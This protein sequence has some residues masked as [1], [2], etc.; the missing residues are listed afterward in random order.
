MYRERKPTS[1][2]LNTAALLMAT[3]CLT[4]V[5]ASASCVPSP[6]QSG[7]L[8]VCTGSD[9]SGVGTGLEENVKLTVSDGAS[10]VYSG[11]GFAVQ[12]GKNSQVT[13]SGSISDAGVLVGAFSDIHN[14]VTGTIEGLTEGLVAVESTI[15]NEGTVESPATAVRIVDAD[16]TNDGTISAI[17]GAGGVPIALD[18]IGSTIRNNGKIYAEGG[19]FSNVVGVFAGN[20]NDLTNDGLIHANA[21]G[22]DGIAIGVWGP[23][24]LQNIVTNNDTIRVDAQGA[25]TGLFLIDGKVVNNGELIVVGGGATGIR[26]NYG[27]DLKNTG[28]IT[29]SGDGGAEAVIAGGNSTVFNS[30]S[31]LASGGEN[32]VGI[33]GGNNTSGALSVWNSGTIDAD[34]AITVT[35][36]DTSGTAVDVD[37]TGKIQGAILLGDAGDKLVN[38]P[39]GKIVGDIVMGDGSDVVINAGL[40]AGDISLG[41]GDDFF[42]RDADAEPDAEGTVDAGEGWDSIGIYSNDTESGVLKLSGGFEAAAVYVEDWAT[43]TIAEGSGDADGMTVSLLGSGLVINDAGLAA[44]SGYATVALKSEG[45]EFRNANSISAGNHGIETWNRNVVINAANAEVTSLNFAIDAGDF[46]DILNAGTL[47]SETG[48][49]RVEFLNSEDMNGDGYA[50]VT[51]QGLI[52]APVGIFVA[53]GTIVGGATSNNLVTNGIDG[54]IKAHT[55]I[56]VSSNLNKI[57]NQG[58]IEGE[59]YGIRIAGKSGNWVVNEA[60]GTVTAGDDGVNVLGDASIVYNAGTIAG[61]KNG[62]EDGGSPDD[63]KAF[64]VKLEGTGG[65][66][67]NVAGQIYSGTGHGIY[68]KGNGVVVENMSDSIAGEGI[69]DS[70]GSQTGIEGLDAIRIEGVGN[71]ITNTGLVYSARNGVSLAGVQNSLGNAGLIEADTAVYLDGIDHTITNDGTL[72]GAF[73]AVNNANGPMTLKNSGLISGDLLLGSSGDTIELS[74]GSRIKGDIVGGS[75]YDSITATGDAVLDG[76]IT[77]VDALAVEDGTLILQLDDGSS[78]TKT[79]VSGGTLRLQGT[80]ATSA[81]VTADGGLAGIGTLQGNV[82]NQGIV[83]PGALNGVLKISG[84]YSQSST[85][86]MFVELGAAGSNKLAVTGTAALDGL[87]VAGLI[88]RDLDALEGKSYTVLTAGS[89]VGSFDTAGTVQQGFWTLDVQ[90]SGTAVTVTVTDVDL[91]IGASAPLVGSL[92]G[93]VRTA[94]D[95]EV[96]LPGGGIIIN[97][98]DA[99]PLGGVISVLNEPVQQSTALDYDSLGDWESTAASYVGG[100]DGLG[101]RTPAGAMPKTGTAAFEGTTQGALTETA[102]GAPE[103]FVVEGN[104]LLTANFASGLVNADFTEMEKIDAAGVASAWVDFRARM[105]IADGT[106]EFA[107]T[108][109]TDDGVW[110]GEARGGFYGDEGGMPGH[111]AGLWSMSSPLGRALGGFLAKRQ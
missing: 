10:I 48:G 77:G 64:G 4:P 107:G 105:S 31:I 60:G 49:I 2:W 36:G 7:D 23:S 13:N 80:V 97:G 51:N 9:T 35:G 68:V 1:A 69:V 29:V 73:A 78:I 24:G 12:I 52:E 66:I 59:A 82:T 20:F 5:G 58:T 89:V 26:T 81:T 18:T 8:I 76:K 40:I 22:T 74:T 33:I 54:E 38:M 108:A 46:N 50:G 45:L 83:T 6:A 27:L 62:A 14:T 17:A 98:G 86:Q 101:A 72:K 41:A 75:G 19:A 100:F 111:A 56:L 15:L 110:N 67:S 88:G 95:I 91:T 102:S 44:K 90:H 16:L 21:I 32:D 39:A 92:A 106:S 93:T 87:L 63:T 94:G 103:A 43:F 42:F 55:G 99:P 96:D 25:S 104:V 28:T 85:G 11:D 109:G 34:I 65:R 79:T 61:G 47:K 57:I 70:T 30:G 3:S 37:N 71:D 84:S 53:L